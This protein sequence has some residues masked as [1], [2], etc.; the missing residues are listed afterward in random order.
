MTESEWLSSTDPARMLAFVRTNSGDESGGEVYPRTMLSAPLAVSD[1][2][3]KLFALACWWDQYHADRAAPEFHESRAWAESWIDRGM[4]TA[5]VEAMPDD[6]SLDGKT[7]IRR[8]LIA[9]ETP[10][11]TA[12]AFLSIDHRDHQAG[13]LRCI[14]GNPFRPVSLCGESL[15]G[16]IGGGVAISSDCR[17]CR[18]ILS[19]NGGTIPR[20]AEAIYQERAWDRMPM[21]A[22]ALEEAGCQDAAILAH[23]R[24]MRLCADCLGSCRLVC[25]TGGVTPWD[26]P[27]SEV[28]PCDC[29]AGWW[30]DA[31]KH[32]RGCWV[33]DLLLGK[34]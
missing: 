20:L 8:W 32:A 16:K 1:R 4:P 28:Q 26:E 10:A 19:W 29:N 34:E 3:L 13:L 15:V 24:G 2:K 31:A 5:E 23:C 14:A 9:W 7:C 17:L 6:W 33:I 25:D 30:P 27:V 18:A 12:A 11:R 22:D 21:L